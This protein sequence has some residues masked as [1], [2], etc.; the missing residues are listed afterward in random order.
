M[1]MNTV[2]ED[3]AF[4]KIHLFSDPEDAIG[5]WTNIKCSAHYPLALIT[6]FLTDAIPPFSKDPLRIRET[7]EH[8]A[9]VAIV[10]NSSLHKVLEFDVKDSVIRYRAEVGDDIKFK[11]A[12]IVHQISHGIETLPIGTKGPRRAE[13]PE[14]GL[15]RIDRN[16]A[17]RSNNAVPRH[18]VS[19]PYGTLLGMPWDRRCVKRIGKCNYACGFAQKIFVTTGTE[20]NMDPRAF[21]SLAKRLLD[22]EKNPEGLRS[23]V[24]RA[25]YAAFNVAAEFFD[26]IGCKVPNGPQDHELAYN[27]LNNCGDE[28]LIQTGSHL[29]NLRGERN[30]A[31]YKLHN[32]HVEKEDVV[33][34]WVDV[35]EELI[36]S[37]DDCKNGP[38]ERRRA[39]AKAVKAYKKAREEKYHE[40][41]YDNR[42]KLHFYSATAG[43]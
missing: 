29:H 10:A 37:L 9:A 12:E 24:S 39:V 33:R 38:A 17:P 1:D 5:R 40:M 19:R 14:F 28:L 35:S 13:N 15:G 16:G 8:K 3:V 42:T 21:L 41:S 18:P 43:S 7:P 34:N 23:T 25:Y 27:Y 20:V 22:K 2:Y 26:G 31:D 32:K 4:M 6:A 11:L 30:T 36:K